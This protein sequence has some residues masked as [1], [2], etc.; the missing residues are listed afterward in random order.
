LPVRIDLIGYDPDRDHLFVGLSVVPYVYYKEPPTGPDA[1]KVLQTLTDL[2][3]V[4]PDKI[5][6]NPVPP[7]SKPDATDIK[8]GEGKSGIP[9]GPSP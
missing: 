6:S 3:T 5:P 1:G 8:R 9:A 2:P 7:A 4:D